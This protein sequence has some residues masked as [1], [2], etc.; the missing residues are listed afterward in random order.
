MAS[1]TT[2]SV[3]T[4]SPDGA[5]SPQCTGGVPGRVGRIDQFRSETL[6]PPEQG[7]VIHLDAAFGEELLEVPVG[8]GVSQVPGT[9]SRITSGGNRN[10]LNAEGACASGLERRLRFIPPPSRAPGDPSTQ[11]NRSAGGILTARERRT[12]LRSRRG[13]PSTATRPTESS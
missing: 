6:H 1:R 12:V 3:T 13:D 8:H 4:T 11:R 9:A 10:P 5:C 7:H 2:T